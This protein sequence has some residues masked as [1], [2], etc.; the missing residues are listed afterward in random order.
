MVRCHS[1]RVVAAGAQGQK[2]VGTSKRRASHFL[3]GNRATGNTQFPPVVSAPAPGD[4]TG[5][6]TA[7]EIESGGNGLELIT[8]R[9]GNGRE[10]AGKNTAHVGGVA[11]DIH[12]VRIS[13][14]K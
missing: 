10:A 5:I 4:A 13:E 3:G 8:A 14:L 9:N 11:I 7:G 2:F 12:I 1:A 6:D